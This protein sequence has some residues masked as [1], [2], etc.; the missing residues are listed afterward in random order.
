MRYREVLRVPWWVYLL[1]AGL[2][3]L[4]AFTFAAVVGVPTAIVIYLIVLVGG[5]VLIW[6]RRTAIIVDD[7]YLRIGS[8][9]LRLDQMGEI[10]ALDEAGMR[11]VAG[12][13]ADPRAHLVLRNLSTK[14]GV[15][16]ELSGTDTP[17]WLVT[18]GRP[19][20]LAEALSRGPSA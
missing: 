12:Q 7:E 6:W 19:E 15:K 20:V 5:W 3:A 14:T 4:L 11:M 16:I 18:S 1:F 10:R 8:Q 2:A 13:N 17:Y 9:R